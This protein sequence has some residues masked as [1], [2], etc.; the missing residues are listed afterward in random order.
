[1]FDRSA[2][3][4]Y[5]DAMGAAARA[6]SVAVATRLES[7]A[8]L[9]ACRVEDFPEAQWWVADEF[10]AVAAEVSAAQNI[11]RA[12]ASAQV[13]LAVSLHARLPRVAEV[14]ARGDIDFRL[15]STVISRT[16][17]VEDEAIGAL[18]EALARRVAK[19]MRLSKKKLRDRVDLFVAKF[20]EAGVRVPPIAKDNRYF[21]VDPHVPGLAFAG[22][23][24]DAMDAAALD[25]RL[26]ALAATV[27][28]E[29]PR[30]LSQRRSDACGALGRLEA[31]LACQCGREE[32]PAAAVRESAAQVVVHV[33]AE[34]GTVEGTSDNPGYL[35]G[36]GVMPAESVREAAATP[37]AKLTPV[38]LP[39]HGAKP[40]PEPDAGPEPEAGYRP[41][42]GLADF[43][44]WR[45]LTCRWP[46][47]DAPVQVCDVDH[48]VAWPFGATHPSNLKHYCR[49]HHLI[50]TFYSGPRG[51]TDRQL[52]DGTIV[53]T[54]PTG[55]IY[56]T[57][58]H[59]GMLFLGL[60]VPT[61]T[62]E[63]AAVETSPNRGAMM[64]RRQQTREQDRR[65]RINR[66]RRQRIEINAEQERRHQA[67]LAATY[68]PPPF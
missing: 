45:D 22:G 26:D 68:E 48:T 11:S 60:A 32:C 55:H 53:L 52:A 23:V 59:G 29:D 18:D 62:V 25:Q 36:F 51:W 61:G 66:E 49:I 43:L 28:E 6:E 64:P 47:C 1:M 10:E 40:E 16:D 13:R 21:D 7:V 50:K 19:W 34:R 39:E 12:R 56:A 37:T 4:W 2:P 14:F 35:A 58:P 17:N 46:G 8:G 9:F 24:L 65:D 27:C 33:L 57:E 31:T 42:A 67:W 38:V 3:R 63:A 5:I 15:V 54:A 41:S 20:D 44:R 30:S